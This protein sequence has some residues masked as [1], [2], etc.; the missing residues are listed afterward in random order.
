MNKLFQTT[1][2]IMIVIASIVNSHAQVVTTCTDVKAVYKSNECCEH[3]T[4]VIGTHKS[5]HFKF[6]KDDLPHPYEGLDTATRDKI[7][8][9]ITSMTLGQKIGEMSMTH[10]DVPHEY[11]V[12]GWAANWFPGTNASHP[13][14]E[15]YITKKLFLNGT[16]SPDDITYLGFDPETQTFL[17][18]TGAMVNNAQWHGDG[19]LGSTDPPKAIHALRN[20]AQFNMDHG[21]PP[22][23]NGNDVIHGF[24]GGLGIFSPMGSTAACGFD[25]SLWMSTI[26]KWRQQMRIMA[27]T[28]NFSPQ[29]DT[30]LDTR[31]GRYP[32]VYSESAIHAADYAKAFSQGMNGGTTGVVKGT[33]VAATVKHFAGYGFATGGRDRANFETSYKALREWDLVAYKAAL[34]EGIG[35]V[36]LNS[37]SVNHEPIHKS[38][39]MITTILRKRLGFNGF[40]MTDWADMQRISSWHHLGD[41]MSGGNNPYRYK[42]TIEM[43]IKNGVDMM[44]T[45]PNQWGVYVKEL[46]AE[47]RLTEEHINTAA[48]RILRQKEAVGLL[49]TPFQIFDGTPEDVVETVLGPDGQG[50]HGADMALQ[51]SVEAITLLKNTGHVL[52]IT[53][54]EKILLTGPNMDNANSGLQCWTANW[55]G[56]MKTSALSANRL[57]FAKT[58]DGMVTKNPKFVSL[59]E[60]LMHSPDAPAGTSFHDGVPYFN[61]SRLGNYFAADTDFSL[62]PS[63]YKGVLMYTEKDIAEIVAKAADATVIVVALGEVTSYAEEQGDMVNMYGI[64]SA[65]GSAGNYVQDTEMDSG[66][67]LAQNQKDLVKTLRTHYPTKK[68]VGV[69]ASPR[70]LIM[71]KEIDMLDSFVF[72]GD[73]GSFG[74][75]AFAEIFFGKTA[76]SGALSFSWPMTD[77]AIDAAFNTYWPDN[78]YWGPS[79]HDGELYPFASSLTYSPIILDHVTA[80]VESGAVKLTV[81]VM[82]NGTVDTKKVVPFYSFPIGKEFTRMGST[83]TPR[84]V[85]YAKPHILAGQTV[86]VECTVPMSAFS[87]VYGS[88][89][90]QRDSVL[91][92]PHHITAITMAND[93]T[94]QNPSFGWTPYASRAEMPAIPALSTESAAHVSTSTVLGT[95]LELPELILEDYVPSNTQS[96]CVYA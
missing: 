90:E 59:K 7:E 6:A 49:D 44:M 32:E 57:D 31:W 2:T 71:T 66:T 50:V 45:P 68:L 62:I 19:A 3:P 1:L 84:L 88:M 78:T 96:T 37:G 42:E 67:H 21:I 11:P 77:T 61:S 14:S 74:G 81:H 27:S 83:S 10:T 24:P 20:A 85:S 30:K 9:Y 95:M 52:P 93:F 25:P 47:G 94:Y 26:D 58:K 86:K 65:G 60:G 12:M 80:A 75:D 16:A 34:D 15:T 69:F 64:G 28:L 89:E 41:G 48:R 18:Q 46:I 55:Q 82:N 56:T 13:G 40:V 5:D 92:V 63:S 53:T 70:P 73:L 76:P 23:F 91:M 72:T 29:A 38:Y 39:E 8:S 87:E 35:A 22:A 4:K 79:G 36:M 51:V 33:S 54:P 17:H 43:M